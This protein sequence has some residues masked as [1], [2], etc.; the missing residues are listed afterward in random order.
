MM[1]KVIPFILVVFFF[2]S[3]KKGNSKSVSEEVQSTI[4]ND[5]IIKT[6]S[7]IFVMPNGEEIEELKKK[8]GEDNFYISADDAS[9]Y[10]AK[11]KEKVKGKNVVF[12]SKNNFIFDKEGVNI[13]K[14]SFLDSWFIIDYTNGKP[15]KYSLVDYYS[16]INKKNKDLSVLENNKNYFVV[17]IDVNNDGALDK[18]IS[19]KPYK[20]NSLY[21]FCKKII[22]MSFP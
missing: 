8:Q 22:V 20:G 13:E 21:F 4:V 6:S 14:D 16:S 9:F 3:C 10:M 5:T 18:V 11:I 1:K 12:S 17:D 2:N 19:S 15:L 7:I